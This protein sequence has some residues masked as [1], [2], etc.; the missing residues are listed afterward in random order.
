MN[1]SSAKTGVRV[2]REL[3]QAI[4]DRRLQPGDRYLSEADALKEHNVSR[5]T[6]REAMRFLEFQGVLSVKAGP[7]GGA[8]VE[9]PDWRNLASTYALLMQFSGTSLVEVMAARKVLEPEMA[10][11]CARNATSEQIAAMETFQHE[12]AGS[13]GEVERFTAAY[14]A[15]WRCVADA[16]GNPVTAELWKALRALVDTG[17][18]VPNE[19][20]RTHLA[21]SMA[22][23]LDAIRNRDE[24][25]ARTLVAGL[26]ATF[27][28]RLGRDYPQRL[29]R[30]VAWSDIDARTGEPPL[31]LPED[32]N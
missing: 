26:D 10:V 20:F 6:Y 9:R 29:G 12:A 30:T 31:R 11:Q 7:G 24:A 5:A 27:A 1:K 4:Y 32:G 25:R 13:I 28:D 19:R 15:F 8:V 21:Q 22:E 18:F 2:A 16:T 17:R 23:L 3:V 14:R